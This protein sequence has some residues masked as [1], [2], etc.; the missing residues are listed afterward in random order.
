[1][2]ITGR[3]RIVRKICSI[4]KYFIKL[5]ANFSHSETL[6]SLTGHIDFQRRTTNIK[7]AKTYVAKL[8]ASLPAGMCKRIRKAQKDPRGIM[9]TEE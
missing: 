7:S 6:F 2:I 9:Q 8:I 3:I 1:M 4:C 5:C